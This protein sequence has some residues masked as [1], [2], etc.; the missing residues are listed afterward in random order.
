MKNNTE[1]DIHS[2]IDFWHSKPMSNH[3]FMSTPEVDSTIKS[4][5]EELWERACTGALDD[6]KHSALGCLALCIVLDQFPLNMFRGDSKA[7]SSEKK[8]VAIC[9]H[10]LD[11]GFLQQLPADK[12]LFLL[13]PLM[14]SEDIQDQ[15]LN[16]ATMSKIA[17]E[18]NIHYAKHH[19]EIIYKFGRFPHRNALLGRTST[20]EEVEWLNSDQAFTG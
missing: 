6:W 1:K 13:M 11:M 8:A 12:T 15:E 9:K 20:P 19:R 5:Y 16:V 18:S 17:G 2:I 4:H 14:H 3:W 10:A 7:W